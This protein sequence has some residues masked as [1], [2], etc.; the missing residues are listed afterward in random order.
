MKRSV[1]LFIFV[2]AFACSL[3]VNAQVNESNLSQFLSSI[4]WTEN[5][6]EDYLQ[7]H[8]TSLSEYESF[9]DLMSFLGEPIDNENLN[10]MLAQ[11]EM[12][13]NDLEVLLAE[14][15]ET[16]DDYT[17]IEDLQLD[18][19]FFLKHHEMLTVANDFLSLFGLTENEMKNLFEHF[20]N[21][22]IQSQLKTAIASVSESLQQL[23]HLQG[24]SEISKLEQQQLLNLWEEVLSLYQIEAKFYLGKDGEMVAV[25][26]DDVIERQMVSEES[27][28]LALHN[29]AGDKLATLVFSNEIVQSNLMYESLEQFNEIAAISEDYKQMHANAKLPK[30]AGH[31]ITNLIVSLFILV[32]GLK[33]LLVARRGV[34][35]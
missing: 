5:D 8:N 22:V 7:S 17:F 2:A 19:Q 16:I 26:V 18:I 27:L 20:Q 35:H 11:Y 32:I 24:A 21:E 30:T 33:L 10:E 28:Y 9:E 25:S 4:N 15:G 13:Y 29:L 31:F 34:S 23:S 6:L 14:Y 3:Q 12:T 1:C